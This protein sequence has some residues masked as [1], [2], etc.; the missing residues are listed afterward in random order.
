MNLESKIF[1]V[2]SCQNAGLCSRKST[3]EPL[4]QKIDC[5]QEEKEDLI[6]SNMASK[7]PTSQNE[8]TRSDKMQSN[9]NNGHTNLPQKSEEISSSSSSKVLTLGCLIY[10]TYS[11]AI[12]VDSQFLSLYYKSKGFGGTTVGM[13]YSITPLTAFLTIPIWGALTR[14]GGNEKNSSSSMNEK[15]T[16]RPFQILC[17]NIIIATMGQVSLAILDKPIYMMIA[18]TVAGIFSSP[19]KPMLDGILMDHLEDSSNVGRVRF[20]MILGSGVGTNLGGRLLELAQNNLLA[21]G[22]DNELNN[23]WTFVS[24]FS[25]GFGLLFLARFILTIPTLICIRQL[26]NRATMNVKINKISKSND[27]T[28]PDLNT[29]GDK[30]SENGKKES[31]S[32]LSVARDVAK[33][34][35]GDRNH[36]L[37]FICIYIAGFSGGVSDVFSSKLR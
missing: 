18:I 34:S 1:A 3:R 5:R 8:T 2:H 31:I 7:V 4:K 32:V 33:H 22:D 16:T 25:S 27:A 19:V 11:V 20:F 30:P 26:Q 29:I 24:E 21:T 13:L 6:E 36:L 23:F 9:L 10:F 35:F 28:K 14:V 17:L 37:F 12:S 15:A